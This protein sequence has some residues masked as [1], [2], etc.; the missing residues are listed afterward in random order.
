[1]NPF[2]KAKELLLSRGL[3][4]VF[5]V[6]EYSPPR[7][8]PALLSQE[9]LDEREDEIRERVLDIVQAATQAQN[10]ELEKPG[11]RMI[12]FDEALEEAAKYMLTPVQMRG[13]VENSDEDYI[14]LVP[15]VIATY[16]MADDVRVAPAQL[17]FELVHDHDDVATDP[18]RRTALTVMLPEQFYIVALEGETPEDLVLR[19][20]DVLDLLL[21]ARQAILGVD[22]SENSD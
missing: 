8:R 21:Q 17:A 9:E 3:S 13:L 6:V 19:A 2:T 10:D 20:G 7:E 12:T 5:H 15:E 18:V 14:P 16:S 11:G 1:V 4:A 22:N